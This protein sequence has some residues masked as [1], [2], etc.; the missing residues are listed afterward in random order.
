MEWEKEHTLRFGELWSGWEY[1]RSPLPR[2]MPGFPIVD[3]RQA[4]VIHFVVEAPEGPWE[5]EEPHWTIAV[6]MRNRCLTSYELYQNAIE[7]QKEEME[8]VSNVFFDDPFVC[9]DLGD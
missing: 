5:S 7:V 3:R 6:D 8:D 2:S 4:D 9:C 1:W